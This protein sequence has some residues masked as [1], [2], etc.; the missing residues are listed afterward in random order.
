MFPLVGLI[1]NGV[2]VLILWVGAHQ[3]AASA[4]QVGDMMAFMQY[5]M[6]VIMSFMMISM[7]FVMVPRAAVSGKR[8]AEV[9]GTESRIHDPQH[10]VPFDA[11]KRG[12]VEFR[13]VNFRYPGAEE[14]ALHDITFTALPGQTTAIIGPTGSGKSTIANLL[15]RF[16]DVTGGEVVVDGA[17]IRQVTQESLREKIGYVPQQGL[18]MS[19]TVASNLRYGNP[20][21]SDDEVARAA[22]VAQADGFVTEMEGGYEAAIAQGG[23]N[24]SGGQRQRL[25]IARALA[26]KPEVLLF[27]D[28]FSA[29]DF[30]TDATL[31][32]ALRDNAGGETVIVVAQRVS[33]I[34]TAEQILVL[35]KGRVVGRGTHRELLANCPEYYEIASSQ[36]AKEELA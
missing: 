35:E 28:S 12:V 32:A 15:L 33:T 26:K 2:S 34:M 22:Q 3:I 29:L 27:D 16:Y 36:L 7:M 23:T 6:Q 31:R 11:K 8:I 18:L 14:D 5:A 13:N 21:A 24:V 4:M 9:L 1:M 30:K 20:A 10:P 25:S 17:D 19:G